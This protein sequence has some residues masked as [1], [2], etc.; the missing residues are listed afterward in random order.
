MKEL[1]TEN[2]HNKSKLGQGEWIQQGLKTDDIT[3]DPKLQEYNLEIS[4]LTLLINQTTDANERARLIDERDAIRYKKTVYMAKLYFKKLLFYFFV[5]SLITFNLIVVAVSMSC[6]I[7][8]SFGYRIF[9]AL[10]AFMFGIIYLVINYK[11][12]KL[13]TSESCV[14][15]PNNPFAL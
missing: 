3:D 13:R 1:F 12:Y 10:C 11:Y 8:D 6:S 14:L 2:N 7:G 9:S 4:K 5:F 15:Q